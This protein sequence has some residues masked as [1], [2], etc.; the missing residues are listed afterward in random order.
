MSTV[1]G[2]HMRSD[3]KS[4]CTVGNEW[5][6]RDGSE[7]RIERIFAHVGESGSCRERRLTRWLMCAIDMRQKEGMS[8]RSTCAQSPVRMVGRTCRF[9]GVAAGEH[10]IALDPRQSDEVFM[11]IRGPHIG[12]IFVATEEE[13]KSV[14]LRV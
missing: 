12:P 8:V 3:R 5:T 13:S 7:R 10:H 14:S 11:Y 2:F 4:S 9:F 6:R 1:R